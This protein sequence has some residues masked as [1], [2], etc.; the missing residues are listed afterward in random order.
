MFSNRRAHAASQGPMAQPQRAA[1]GLPMGACLHSVHDG[2]DP[3]SLVLFLTH[4][5]MPPISSHELK[6]GAYHHSLEGAQKA[7]ARE[8][9]M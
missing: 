4:L 8:G 7:A 3:K 9:A 5:I 2:R 1:L 6:F